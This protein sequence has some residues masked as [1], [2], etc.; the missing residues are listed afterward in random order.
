LRLEFLRARSAIA[1]AGALLST[2]I[3]AAVATAAQSD[4]TQAPPPQAVPGPIATKASAALTLHKVRHHVIA[5]RRV[6]VTGVL[7]P[8]GAGRWVQLRVRGARGWRVVD[9]DETGPRGSFR[10]RWRTSGPGSAAL[11]VVFNGGS[12]LT[13]ADRGAGHAHVYRRAVASWYGPGFYGSHLG[14]G[15]RLG[16]GTVGVAHKTLPCG[17]KLTL[18]YRGRSVR[19]R[20]IDRGPYIPGREFDLTRATKE[21]LHFGSTGVVLSTR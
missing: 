14:C 7:H 13:G 9:R 1:V 10:L 12:R 20:V 21:R 18:R 2:T 8:R 17:S 11:R 6:V 19:V 4:A 15:G 5:G 3:L 16:Y